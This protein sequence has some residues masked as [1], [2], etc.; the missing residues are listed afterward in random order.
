MVDLIDKRALGI[1]P[2]QE[3]VNLSCNLRS[4]S[5]FKVL[6]APFIKALNVIRYLGE[7]LCKR[8]L[9]SKAHW[10]WFFTK[11]KIANDKSNFSNSSDFLVKI[12]HRTIAQNDLLT[13]NSSQLDAHWNLNEFFGH[14]YVLNL[15][16]IDSSS[17]AHKQRLESIRRHLKAV[18]INESQYE[19]FRGTYGK[20]ELKEE[21]WRRIYD[22]TFCKLP[23][24][25]LE[26]QHKGQAGCFWSHYKIIKDAND[27]YNNALNVFNTATANFK[28]AAQSEKGQAQN[29]ME[30]AAKK[31][32]E[33][34]SILIVEDDT[35]FGK[36]INKGKSYTLEKVGT[37]FR[38]AMQELPTDWDMLYLMSL[39]FGGPLN[40][41]PAIKPSK[42]SLNLG[43]LSWGTTTSAY[44]INSKMYAPLLKVLSKIETAGAKLEALDH[45]IASLHAF[46]NCFVI[47]PPVAFQGGGESHITGSKGVDFWDGTWNRGY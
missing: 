43:K 26:N 17:N 18:G 2:W 25:K 45:E 16:D 36:I 34:S 4:E 47:T 33:Y 24:K 28:A 20:Y 38:K 6:K 23:G 46:N 10:Q 39:H 32:K 44:A 15:D 27:K 12:D 8:F 9:S 3:G 22:N 14:I 7:E 35:G 40:L 13:K 30:E 1:L 21:V 19:R 37:T 29:K 42:F 31:V 41:I 11:R 5:K